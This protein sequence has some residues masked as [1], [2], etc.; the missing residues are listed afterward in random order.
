VGD[1]VPT[2]P[3]H[4]GPMRESKYSGY[5]CTRETAEGVYGKRKVKG[6]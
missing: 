2:G 3:D 6:Q 1:T 5:P 4:Y